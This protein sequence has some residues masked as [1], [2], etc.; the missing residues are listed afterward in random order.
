MDAPTPTEEMFPQPPD[1][2]PFKSALPDAPKDPSQGGLDLQWALELVGKADSS[3][4]PKAAALL[5]R[6]QA[7]YKDAMQVPCPPPNC[8][9][10]HK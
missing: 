8:I 7:L 5:K 6:V 9:P 2:D 4:T 10:C 3:L 1:F